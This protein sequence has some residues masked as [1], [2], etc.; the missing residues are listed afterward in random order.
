MK[1]T[2]TEIIWMLW[3]AR[4]GKTKAYETAVA[5]YKELLA[6]GEEGNAN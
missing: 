2:Q 5:E 6:E 3:N 1:H 4:P